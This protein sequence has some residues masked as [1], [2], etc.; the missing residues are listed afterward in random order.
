M[1]RERRELAKGMKRDPG[2]R[3]TDVRKEKS[4]KQASERGETFNYARKKGTHLREATQG[5]VQ[6]DVM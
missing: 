2:E 6:R 1:R 5:V 3:S 4:E